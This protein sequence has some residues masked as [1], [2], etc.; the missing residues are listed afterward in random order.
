[1]Q[2]PY[3]SLMFRWN[4]TDFQDQKISSGLYLYK[5]DLGDRVYTGKIPYLK[6]T[7]VFF[8]YLHFL[9]AHCTANFK[10]FAPPCRKWIACVVFRNGRD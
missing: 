8:R 2:Q 5:I 4:G 7:A 1:M 6:L 10:I 9:P 3:R